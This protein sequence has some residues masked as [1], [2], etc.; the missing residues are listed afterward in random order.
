MQYSGKYCLF[1]P[2]SEGFVKI[3]TSSQLDCEGVPK[4]SMGLRRGRKMLT[5]MRQEAEGED[6]PAREF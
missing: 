1:I 2:Q 5:I 3:F 4:E 6:K